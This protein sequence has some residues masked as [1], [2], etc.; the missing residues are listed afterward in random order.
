MD[1]QHHEKYSIIKSLGEGAYGKVF[2]VQST[3]TSQKYALKTIQLLSKDPQL[4]E[5]Y[6]T[7]IKALNRI[8]NVN[9]IRIKES[10]ITSKPSLCLNIITEYVDGC[11]LSQEIQA[12]KES[13]KPFTQI[14]LTD[15]IIQIALGLD[16][17]HS[18]RIIHRDIKPNNI[19]L[20]KDKIAK[21]GDFGISKC[22]NFTFEK[23][24]TMCL[25][26]PFYLAPEMCSENEE[27]EQGYT[28]KVDMWSFGITLYEMITF[29]KPFYGKTFPA[30]V[31]K[32]IS[33]KYKE[34]PK[35]VPRDLR[36]LVHN[37]LNMNPDERYS[38][39]DIL[40]L[41][42]IQSRM[43]YLTSKKSLNEEVIPKFKNKELKPT[44]SFIKKGSHGIKLHNNINMNSNITSN[45]ETIQSNNS[46]N[47]PNIIRTNTIPNN[48]HT[49]EKALNL[50]HMDSK[51][52]LI[53]D[54][55][56]KNKNN[57]DNTKSTSLF[58]NTSDTKTDSCSDMQKL[59]LSMSHIHLNEDNDKKESTVKSIKSD[60][61][62]RYKGLSSIN[63]NN[64]DNNICNVDCDLKDP[65][66]KVKGFNETCKG[67][68]MSMKNNIDPNET[69]AFVSLKES[70]IKSIG[71]DGFKKLCNLSVLCDD[72][73]KEKFKNDIKIKFIQ[74]HKTKTEITN[75]LK[76]IDQFYSYG[77]LI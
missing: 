62:L 7:E 53:P 36:H 56:N 49:N 59:I 46:D 5:K 77:E 8:N 76:N 52:T 12:Q 17:I 67:L 48:K 26:T 10:F 25:G 18:I 60:N 42:F 13:K 65:E 63:D 21:I 32:I 29:Q 70:I 27:G 28:S 40:K 35:S 2:L 20:T 75:E 54:S 57:L 44:P 4:L 41:G 24:L 50:I 47:V 30:V 64:E 68:S 14:Q 58:G 72:N 38:A 34:L 37:L 73:K 71:E 31:L 69:K 45:R 51:D 74:E 43:Q 15:W 9:V 61:S 3:T 39:K 1:K 16:V 23:A 55:S 6:K 66:S 19:F 33:G 22:L 11:D